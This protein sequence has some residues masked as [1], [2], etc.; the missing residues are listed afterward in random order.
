MLNAWQLIYVIFLQTQSAISEDVCQPTHDL[1]SNKFRAFRSH[2]NFVIDVS[3]CRQGR[4]HRQEVVG[5]WRDNSGALWVYSA[6]EVAETPNFRGR[7]A[8]VW[9]TCHASDDPDGSKLCPQGTAGTILCFSFMPS[10][11]DTLWRNFTK[12]GT[13]IMCNKDFQ[14]MYKLGGQKIRGVK[15]LNFQKMK[16]LTFL[17]ELWRKKEKIKK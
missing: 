13:R 9:H 5:L 16:F 3:T 17:D 4:H 1:A 14:N 7:C 15:I 2:R 11:S 8:L 10:S 6:G 12:F